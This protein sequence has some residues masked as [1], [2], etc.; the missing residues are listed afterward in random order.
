MRQMLSALKRNIRY[1][2]QTREERRHAL[3]GPAHLWKLKRDFQID[4]LKKMNLQPQH[5]LLDI[6]CGT[7][8]GGI[9]FITFLQEGHYFGIDVRANALAEA[10]KELQEAGLVSKKPNLLLSDNMSQLTIEQTFD[11][12]WAFSVLIH[13]SDDILNDTLG[14]VSKH[15]ADGGV[16]YANVIC[17]DMEKCNWEEFPV[18]SRTIDSYIDKCAKYGLIVSDIGPLNIHGHVTNVASHDTQRML[19]ITKNGP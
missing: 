12:I 4:F 19:K 17:D 15:L 6:G 9:P 2:L 11:Y 10:R 14:F 5:Y 8:R 3:V 13:M 7:L 16:F 1:L 18:V